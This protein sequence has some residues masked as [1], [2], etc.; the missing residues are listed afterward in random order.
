MGRL[1]PGLHVD[2]KLDQGPLM[3]G[4]LPGAIDGSVFRRQP[5]RQCINTKSPV[6]LDRD[7]QTASR[8]PRGR[9]GTYILVFSGAWQHNGDSL[10]I[11]GSLSPQIWEYAVT[12]ADLEAE[13]RENA[14]TLDKEQNRLHDLRAVQRLNF[15]WLVSSLAVSAFLGWAMFVGIWENYRGIFSVVGTLGA[16][17]STALAARMLLKHKP[18]I[19]RLR[20]ELYE[21]Q[22][23]RL[24]L[25]AAEEADPRIALR[26]YRLQSIDDIRDL[27]TRAARNKRSANWFQ[28]II[29]IGSVTATSLTGAAATNVSSQDWFRWLAAGISAMVS[30]SAGATGFFKFRERSFG[31]QQTAD[32]IKRHYKAVELRVGEY[33]GDDEVEIL[34]RFASNIEAI[35]D[36][37]RKRELQLEDSSET[38]D[39]R[40]G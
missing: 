12:A 31:Q 40:Q 33:E 39:T 13:R 34:R 15:I 11:R 1:P 6:P 35:K 8:G 32:T 27:E 10:T 28:W 5:S 19:D 29:I 20:Y 30:I 23:E 2:V 36:E 7:G 14:A 25:A 22:T 17:A 16:L 21:L 3:L 9:A 4:R 38:K 18:S 26:I 37:Q 24:H